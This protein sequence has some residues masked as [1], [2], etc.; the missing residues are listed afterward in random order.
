MTLML[1]KRDLVT[2]GVLPV[3]SLQTQWECPSNHH[4]VTLTGLSPLEKTVLGLVTLSS[5]KG[6]KDLVHV[7][8]IVLLLAG[9]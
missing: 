6:T 3:I 8:I 9:D 1:N 4:L 2:K 5:S 7:V